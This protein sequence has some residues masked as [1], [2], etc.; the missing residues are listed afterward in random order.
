MHV[1]MVRNVGYPE[2]KV[3][4]PC[5][6]GNPGIERGQ[7]PRHHDPKAATASCV[8]LTPRRFPHHTVLLHMPPDAR[9][10]AERGKDSS[11]TEAFNHEEASI[12]S[13]GRRVAR[14]RMY[15]RRIS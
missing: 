10:K 8:H 15:G 5:G 11:I 9:R 3:R 4:K 12:S 7:K 14:T 2:A 6:L 13:R 1:L